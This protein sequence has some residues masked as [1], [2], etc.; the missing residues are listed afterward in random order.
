MEISQK[1]AKFVVAAKY[2]DLSERAI[3]VAKKDVLDFVGCALIGVNT[4]IGRLVKG[5]VEDVGGAPQSTVLGLNLK[6]SQQ[7]TAFADGA[8]GHSID[9]DNGLGYQVYRGEAPTNV[10]VGHVSS[11]ILPAALAVGESLKADGRSLLTAYALGIEVAC[12]VAAAVQPSLS[13][14][15]YHSTPKIGIF[16]AAVAA[17][18]LLGLDE[19]KLAYALGIAASESSGLSESF[20][21]MTKPIQVGKAAEG[22]VVAALLAQRGCTAAKNIFEGSLGGFCRAVADNYYLYKRRDT[23]SRHE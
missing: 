23:C 12:R 19:E 7:I 14:R 18:K 17:G 16:G 20:G 21:S 6:T 8:L 1:I 4:S 11:P 9:Y 13:N 15:G 10:F 2:E 5:Y 3:E 22:G